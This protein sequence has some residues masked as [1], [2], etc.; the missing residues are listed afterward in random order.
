[1][2]GVHAVEPPSAAMTE[3]THSRR[4]GR[5]RAVDSGLLGKPLAGSTVQ[6][7]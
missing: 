2:K 3:M 6:G 1:M 4:G 7:R 5:P